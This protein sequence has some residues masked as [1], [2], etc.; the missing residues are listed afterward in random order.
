MK[1]ASLCVC[2]GQV[3]SRCTCACTRRMIGARARAD[4]DARQVRGTRV[5]GVIEQECFVVFHYQIDAGLHLATHINELVPT[6]CSA[7]R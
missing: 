5:G 7:A 6:I 1:V 2:V 4:F 3:S